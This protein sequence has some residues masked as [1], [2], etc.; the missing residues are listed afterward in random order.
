MTLHETCKQGCISAYM[1]PLIAELV[2]TCLISL[3]GAH[4]SP[5]LTAA[6][7]S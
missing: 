1:T 5:A 6:L 2:H 7:P 4:S 3:A